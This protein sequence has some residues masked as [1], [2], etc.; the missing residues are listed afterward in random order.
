MSIFDSS[1][2]WGQGQGVYVSGRVTVITSRHELEK[3][4]QLRI[5]RVAKATQ[6]IT[7]FM[8]ASPRRIY[9]CSPEKIWL[10]VDH[11][12]QDITVDERIE[13][14]LIDLQTFIKNS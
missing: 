4:R 3:I 7:D 13:V 11:K 8:G 14:T 5:G 6:P 9:K 12:V 1:R 10:N 2:P